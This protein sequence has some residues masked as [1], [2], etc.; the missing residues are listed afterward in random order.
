M[1]KSSPAEADE[2]TITFI[3]SFLADI[4]LSGR[5]RHYGAQPDQLEQLIEQAM[6]DPCHKTNAVPV[7]KEDFRKLYQ[8]VL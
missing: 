2:R 3:A 1:I 8:E 5:L 6:A 7:S 4:G